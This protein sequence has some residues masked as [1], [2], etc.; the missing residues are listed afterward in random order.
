[1]SDILLDAHFHLL[2]PDIAY[3]WMNDVTLPLLTHTQAELVGEFSRNGVVGGVVVQAVSDARE[4]AVLLG[5]SSISPMVL[6]VVGWLDLTSRAMEEDLKRVLESPNGEK[7][8]GLRHQTHDEVDPSWLRRLDVMRNL[9]LVANSGLT[10]DLLIRE[11]EIPAA[12]A[13]A[14]SLPQLPLII[15]HLAKPIPEPSKMQAWYESLSSLAQYPN[16]YCKLSGLVTEVLPLG[17]WSLE[18]L[19]PFVVAGLKVFG[20]N[21]CLFASDWPICRLAATYSQVAALTSSALDSLAEQERSA[22]LYK[23]AVEVY[24]LHID[25]DSSRNFIEM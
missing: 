25:Q 24:Q 7:L 18:Q 15:D 23:N 6:G 17:N 14:A 10:F 11:R 22:V 5:I 2:R 9:E 8:V 1:L 3:P 4:T 21:R 13:L 20:A 16:T 19:Q 12:R